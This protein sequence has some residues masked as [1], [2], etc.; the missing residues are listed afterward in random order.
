MKDVIESLYWRLFSLC[1]WFYQ[2][3]KSVTNIL[4]RSPTS[5]T[6][7]QGIWSPTSVTNIVLSNS[8]FWLKIFQHLSRIL[9]LQL[10]FQQMIMGFSFKN[11]NFKCSVNQPRTQVLA[12]ALWP[13]TRVSPDKR[14][15]QTTNDLY[16][17]FFDEK[18]L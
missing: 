16:T 1:W 13:L 15:S 5:Q 14:N 9:G 6:C 18:I 3:I 17:F 8:Y 2:R 4:N 12:L 7:H 10:G 11:P